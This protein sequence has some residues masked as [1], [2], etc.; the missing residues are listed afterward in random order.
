M[1]IG[2][3]KKRNIDSDLRRELIVRL[4]HCSREPSTPVER[5]VLAILRREG[6]TPLPVLVKRVASEL[7][8]DELAAG[9]YVL[10]LGMFGS[11]LFIADASKGIKAANGVLWQIEQRS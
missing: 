7:F 2:L 4:E 6:P 9:A 10:D 1:T 5:L 3:T 11:A 8:Q